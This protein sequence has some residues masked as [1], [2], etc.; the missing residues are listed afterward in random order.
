[1]T[2]YITT[3]N[4]TTG[5]PLHTYEAWSANQIE[6][7][8]NDGYAAAKAWGKQPLSAR[9]EVVRRLADEL[10]RQST[11]FADLI[12][13]EMGKVKAEAAG[14]LEKSAV[15]ATYYADNAARIL[16]DE[17]ASIDGV[18]AWVSYEPIGLVLAVM[19][20][21]FPV[22]Q[23]MR[24]A[25]PAIT[26]G[27]GVLLKHSPN[28]TGCALALEQLFIDAG[29]PKGV[30]T[31][32]VVAEP[33]VPD[34]I[35]R[36]IQDDRIAAV[37]LTGSNRAGAAVGAAAGRASKRS[38]LEL[39]GSDAFIILDD[40]DVP[41]AAAAAVKARYH[42]AG[43]SCV[44]AKRFIVSE[45]IA[46]EFTERFV[47]GARALVVGDPGAAGT[48]MGPLARGD[49]RDALDR[50][51]RRSLEAGAVLLAGGQSVEGPGN[52]YEATVLGGTGPGMAAFDE[53]TFGPLAAIAIAKDDT[54]AMRLANATPFGLSVSV[55][56]SST[57]RALTVAKGVTSGAAFINAVTASDARVP[58]GGT[59]KSGYGRE[60]ASA[61]IREFT[62]TRTYWSV[63][64]T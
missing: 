10:R 14:E 3:V 64:A 11:A 46:A 5:A 60:L 16:A 34:V 39:G 36:L 19:P 51:V 28:V 12:T 63:S 23:V 32:M 54:D 30:V 62:N 37:T 6:Q 17:K 50:Q 48:Q 38:V 59:K 7:A 35:D 31:T 25:I 53:E 4:P 57:E 18:D 21:N 49:L 24:F 9:V 43:Q 27:N 45:S 1:M 8:V 61:G 15:T 26:A 42:N 52:F 13:T 2:T 22:W 29:L 56:S 58:F 55:W 44:C 47:N 33:D 20:W 41:A 40:A